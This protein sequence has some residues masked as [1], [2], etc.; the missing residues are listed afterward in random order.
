MKKENE[1]INFLEEYHSIRKAYNSE[2][3]PKLLLHVCCGACSCYPLIFLTDLFDI[4]ILFSNSNINPEEEFLT[5]YNALCKHVKFLNEGIN[6]NIKV[7]LD[8]YDYNSF[9]DCLLPYKDEK[10]GGNRCKICISKRMK[11]GFEFAKLNGFSYFTTVMSISRNKD[12]DFINQVGRELE[13]QYGVKFIVEDFKKNNGQDIGVK[14]SKI[15][16][17]YRQEY[18]GCEFSFANAKK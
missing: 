15:E 13:K 10:E 17:I 14:I 7:V 16:G 11:R 4:T 5:R 2:S 18:C 9:R 12:A 1:Y 6:A 8:S 3:L